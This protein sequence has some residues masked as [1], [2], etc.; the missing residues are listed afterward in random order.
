MSKIKEY[1]ERIKKLENKSL[2]ELGDLENFFGKKYRGLRIKDIYKKDP[3]YIEWVRTLE[4]KTFIGNDYYFKIEFSKR[5]MILY[6]DI[7]DYLKNSGK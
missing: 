7:M 2:D 3:K 6:A 1:E 4:T 5:A